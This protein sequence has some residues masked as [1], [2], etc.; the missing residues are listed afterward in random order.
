M[1]ILTMFISEKKRTILRYLKAA[2]LH[3]FGKG[4]R[5]HQ[6][7]RTIEGRYNGS[8]HDVYGRTKAAIY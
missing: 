5:F 4:D 1:D 7:P 2:Y 6:E 3:Y 8:W